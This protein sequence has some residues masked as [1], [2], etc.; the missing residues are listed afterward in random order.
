MLYKS[1]IG[2]NMVLIGVALISL[3]IVICT[4]FCLAR[5]NLDLCGLI[6]AILGEF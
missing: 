5:K 2:L 3:V 4:F 1:F 6:F